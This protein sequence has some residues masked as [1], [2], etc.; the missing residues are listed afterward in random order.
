MPT[1]SSP[2]DELFGPRL[3]K[4]RVEKGLTQQELAVA[5]SITLV[6]LARLEKGESQ[7]PSALIVGL[8]AQALGVSADYLIEPILFEREKRDITEIK[9]LEEKIEFEA[10]TAEGTPVYD[11]NPHVKQTYL[12]FLRSMAED[13]EE[14]TT[15]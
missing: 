15:S 8:F 14:T 7:D 9:T 5:A 11:I 1:P 13:Q 3:Q 2:D 12:K 10:L 4:L 6:Y